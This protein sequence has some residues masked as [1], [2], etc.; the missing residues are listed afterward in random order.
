MFSKYVPI[1]VGAALVL[2]GCGASSLPDS[3]T[4]SPIPSSSASPTVNP[5]TDLS[6]LVVIDGGAGTYGD[7]SVTFT[8]P[9]NS[10]LAI[11]DQPKKMVRHVTL[12]GLVNN[13][14]NLFPGVPAEALL[15]VPMS[16]GDAVEAVLDLGQP[17]LAAEGSLTFP[18]SLRKGGNLPPDLTEGG[19]GADVVPGTFGKAELF[20]DD[21]VC[22]RTGPAA[23]TSGGASASAAVESGVPHATAGAVN[24]GTW[25]G[26]D[27]ANGAIATRYGGDAVD[28]A[29]VPTVAVPAQMHYCSPNDCAC[30]YG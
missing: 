21:C 15:R 26:T 27:V 30:H 8:Q 25:F 12:D 20:I 29:Y 24:A 10:V 9:S 4:A 28:P 18:A 2:A 23:G 7:G 13:W 14:Q 22:R 16:G 1:A 11:T 19:V 5:V 17:A 3:P 6:W